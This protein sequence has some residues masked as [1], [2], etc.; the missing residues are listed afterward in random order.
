MAAAGPHEQRL[1]GPPDRAL[2]V[3]Q[4]GVGE[5]DAGRLPRRRRPAAHP[6]ADRV[7]VQGDRRGRC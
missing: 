1:Q 3:E 4:E 5:A 6:L 7:A 2:V